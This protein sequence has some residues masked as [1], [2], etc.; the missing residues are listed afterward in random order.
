MFLKL[1]F[2]VGCCV[3]GSEL[4]GFSNPLNAEL[5]PNCRLLA[6]L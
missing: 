5:N 6:L 3:H 4:S 1:H 2:V